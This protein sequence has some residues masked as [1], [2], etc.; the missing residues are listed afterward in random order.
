M[1]CVVCRHGETREGRTL[2]ALDRGGATVV[3]RDVP[4]QLCQ[5]CGEA[6]LSEETTTQLLKLAESAARAGVQ[7]EVRE[8]LAA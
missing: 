2:T 4:S 7:V 1:K 5:N 3:I 8:Y 6:Y